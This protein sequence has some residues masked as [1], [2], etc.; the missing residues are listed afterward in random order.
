M[1]IQVQST[2]YNKNQVT[3]IWFQNK[4]LGKDFHWG[5]DI[6]EFK[7]TGKKQLNLWANTFGRQKKIGSEECLGISG[8]CDSEICRSDCPD[9]D[10]E[11]WRWW[12]GNYRKLPPRKKKLQGSKWVFKFILWMSHAKIIFCI[13]LKYINS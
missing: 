10:D 8:L 11:Q 12:W 13:S 4:Y 2:E 7:R 6:S 9:K 5:R 3:K 1:E